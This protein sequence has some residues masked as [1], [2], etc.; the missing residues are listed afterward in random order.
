M[1]FIKKGTDIPQSSIEKGKGGKIICIIYIV[2][3]KK[4]E[5]L[6]ATGLNQLR[7]IEKALSNVI[8]LYTQFVEWRS[9]KD[10]YCNLKSL[11]L[12]SFLNSR[13]I[14]QREMSA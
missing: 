8:G 3:E 7:H 2:K 6:T 11:L 1:S 4:I 9:G 5:R 10:R 13:M 14:P 12:H